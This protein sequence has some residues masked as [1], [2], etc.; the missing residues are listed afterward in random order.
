M[1]KSFSIFF[2]LA[3]LS[4][5][6]IWASFKKHNEY[7]ANRT[8]R[9]EKV[10]KKIKIELDWLKPK[11]AAEKNNAPQ[12]TKTKRE[13]PQEEVFGSGR[14][15]SFQRVVLSDKYEDVRWKMGGTSEKLN[16]C[17][18]FVQ[19]VLR[20][21][22][23][24]PPNMPARLTTDHNMTHIFG[25]AKKCAPGDIVHYRGHMGFYHSPGK[26]LGANSGQ[27]GVGIHNIKRDSTCYPNPCTKK[28]F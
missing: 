21:K 14:Q 19:R 15:K 25:P 2:V 27:G 23:C 12:A 6:P 10:G 26:F 11:K 13:E 5:T 24:T 1:K 7:E 3:F 16:D 4:S 9:G 20:E 28:L 18:Y 8:E 22:G 17:S